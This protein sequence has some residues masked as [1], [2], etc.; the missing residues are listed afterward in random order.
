VRNK[1]QEKIF[2]YKF[3]IIGFLIAIPAGYWTFNMLQ[4]HAVRFPGSDLVFGISV[5]VFVFAFFGVGLDTFNRSRLEG[6]QDDLCSRI[7]HAFFLGALAGGFYFIIIFMVLSVILMVFIVLL[8]IVRGE[9]KLFSNPYES[10][11]G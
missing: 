1:I 5:A 4:N 11:E 3:F 10:S 2:R 6:S 7:R 8:L 9:L